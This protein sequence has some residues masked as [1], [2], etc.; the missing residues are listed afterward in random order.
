MVIISPLSMK[1][2]LPHPSV[3]CGFSE[4]GKHMEN[5]L[6]RAEIPSGGPCL[7]PWCSQIRDLRTEGGPGPT[8]IFG[9]V[10]ARVYSTKCMK[11]LLQA[12]V[13]KQHNSGNEA[14]NSGSNSSHTG[15]LTRFADPVHHP[16]GLMPSWP[17][18]HLEA[19]YHTL[20][21]VADQRATHKGSGLWVRRRAACVYGT[22]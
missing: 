10:L 17:P 18:L 9:M 21:R 13:L 5:N 22:G 20:A 11:F 6:P 1:S 14:G 12:G 2:H 19:S 7:C 4:F 15:T 3:A 16:P 8:R